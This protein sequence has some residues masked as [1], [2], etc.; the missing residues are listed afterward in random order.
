[1]IVNDASCGRVSHTAIDVDTEMRQLV[2]IRRVPAGRCK[3]LAAALLYRASKVRLHTWRQ[4]QCVASGNTSVVC[5]DD[6]LITA[7]HSVD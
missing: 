1:M 5:S 7:L 4:R 2:Y 3:V 6:V